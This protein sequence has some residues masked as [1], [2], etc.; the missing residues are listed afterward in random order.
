MARLARPRL[1]PRAC[2]AAHTGPAR[3]VGAD[4]SFVSC[5]PSEAEI[6]YPPL[7]FLSPTGRTHRMESDHVVWTVIEVE[8][9]FSS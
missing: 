5:F 3:G 6:C 2:Q 8:P 7:T 9:R 4:L 1:D